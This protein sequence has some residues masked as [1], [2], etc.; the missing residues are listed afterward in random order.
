MITFRA[1]LHC[2]TT[3][4][5][6]TVSP[7]EIIKLAKQVGMSG[8]SI[9]DHDTIEAYQSAVSCAKTEG[10]ELIPGVEFSTTHR[11]VS[12]HILG[13]AFSLKSDAIHSLCK[14]HRERRIKRYL[15]ILEKLEQNDMPI[16][17]GELLSAHP[18]G[19]IGRPHIALAMMQKG[20]V[21]SV[22]QAF[23]KYLG[24]GKL[25]YTKGHAFPVEETIDVIHKGGG[26]AVIAHP[27]LIRN[28]SIT[29]DLLNMPF[30]G[31]EGYYARFPPSEE[32]KWI[33]IGKEKGWFITG[34]SDFHGEVK[35]HLPLGC[36]WV[37]PETF[38]LLSD[39]YANVS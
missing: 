12:I 3:C 6:G 4:S 31:I 13:Y 27:H 19:S 18:E 15:A 39:H 24:E 20:Y 14:K 2:H 22:D 5:D 30:D 17:E 25:C 7:R 34:G 38:Q 33:E 28:A 8:L 11:G 10:L 21:S 29:Q 26:L 32:L 23:K 1:D 16:S 35:P 36:S 37:G 9:T